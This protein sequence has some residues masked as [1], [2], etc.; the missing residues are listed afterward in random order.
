MSGSAPRVDRAERVVI[1]AE[2]VVARTR[3][4]W[5]AL[6]TERR[7]AAGACLLLF[8]SLFAPWYQETVVVGGGTPHSVSASLTG[9][10]AFSFAEAVL[11]VVSGGVLTLLVRRAEGRPVQVPGG[12]GSAITAAGAAACLVIIW[13]IFDKSGSAGRG[14]YAPVYG[15]DWGIIL[16]LL[17]A[18]ALTYAGTRIRRTRDPEPDL[19]APKAPGPDL[20]IE[21]E[22]APAPAR[23]H[24]PARPRGAARL[25]P[26]E[27]GDLQLAD[28]PASPLSRIPPSP[29][30][31]PDRPE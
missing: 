11:L 28:P 24:R 21:G 6:P 15:I 19:P 26:E 23:V 1:V 30:R 2:A 10:S 17:V 5:R 20:D 9:W 29:R 25:D 3:T 8:L 18:G 31:P 7:V 4:V 27:I 16:A 13:R 14:Q 22:W 12:D